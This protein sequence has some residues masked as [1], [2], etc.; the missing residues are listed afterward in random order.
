ML[1]FCHLIG[2]ALVAFFYMIWEKFNSDHTD[3]HSQEPITE[4]E[5]FIY[6]IRE[7]FYSDY[8]DFQSQECETD[9]SIKYIS[10]PQEPEL[11][12]KPENIEKNEV[13]SEKGKPIS[14]P[15]DSHSQER[16]TEGD[17]SEKQTGKKWII[18]LLLAAAVLFIQIAGI[19]L[20]KVEKN[21]AAETS[22]TSD[23]YAIE[24]KDK[25]LEKAVRKATGIKSRAIRYSDVK[26]IR[27]LNL[28]ARN[29][30]DI[31]ALGCL[32]NLTSL[33]LSIN[34]ISDIS[35]LSGLTN[36]TDLDLGYNT[37]SDITALSG[38]TNLTDLDLGHNTISDIT[39]LSGLTNLT[40]LGLGGNSIS[41]ISALSSLT[42]LTDLYLG[43]IQI[44]DINP[45]NGLTNLTDLDLPYNRISDISALGSLTNL[46]NL[47]L[48]DNQISDISALGSLTN[49][50]N[51]DL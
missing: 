32:T 23:D 42:K 29:I 30:S 44:T 14:D 34:Q 51:L 7:K 17:N 41:D 36:L 16:K 25:A 10:N 5:T 43:Y 19:A 45:L 6:M 35:A 48:N 24:W 20:W 27:R 49:L 15:T 33:D 13:L 39:A 2:I 28:H 1:V 8:P 47:N 22:K 37:I 46:I 21:P 50:I 40:D 31:S 11:S 38:L 18:P 3:F 12:Q 26:S 9:E 4:E